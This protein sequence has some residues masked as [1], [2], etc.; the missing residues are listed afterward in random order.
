M[1]SRTIPAA[2]LSAACL[3]SSLAHASYQCFDANGRRVGWADRADQCP[4]GSAVEAYKPPDLCVIPGA[5]VLG[6]PPTGTQPL[7]FICCAFVSGDSAC[8]HVSQAVDCPPD[9]FLAS[10]EWGY[11]EADGTV[12]CFD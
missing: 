12:T 6:P 4:T 1:I 10:C 2:L 5:C 3:A 8:H 9:E 7:E 11:T